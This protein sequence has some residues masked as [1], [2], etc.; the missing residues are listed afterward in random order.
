M[1]KHLKQQKQN[2]ESVHGMQTK[3]YSQV[4]RSSQNQQT[5]TPRG[6][7]DI[8]SDVGTADRGVSFVVVVVVVVLVVVIE[9]LMVAGAAAAVVVVA[10]AVVVVVVVVVATM[11]A[12]KVVM[13][14]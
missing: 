10:A 8:V 1:K 6:V 3:F 14:K 7:D 2:V 9:F 4:G 11:R 13:F 5:P 12:M